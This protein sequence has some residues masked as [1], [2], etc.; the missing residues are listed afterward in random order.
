MNALQG[1]LQELYLEKCDLWSHDLKAEE[2]STLPYGTCHF[3]I[4]LDLFIY[5]FYTKS[6]TK[7]NV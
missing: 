3:Y 6:E 4:T 5:V 2:E 7:Y 1:L